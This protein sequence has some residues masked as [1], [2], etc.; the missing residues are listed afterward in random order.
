MNCYHSH[1]AAHTQGYLRFKMHSRCAT[2]MCFILLQGNG[3][4]G[5]ASARDPHEGRGMGRRKQMKNRGKALVHF[6]RRGC[7]SCWV[8]PVQGVSTALPRAAGCVPELY[9]CCPLS[10]QSLGGHNSNH[11]LIF[12]LLSQKPQLS[13]RHQLLTPHPTHPAPSSFIIEQVIP[14]FPH[15]PLILGRKLQFC[16]YCL[17]ALRQV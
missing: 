14:T 2:G 13:D 9:P 11:C 4:S 3:R 12:S 10:L 8:G 1:H 17:G 5:K 7:N 15:N 6:S 16:L